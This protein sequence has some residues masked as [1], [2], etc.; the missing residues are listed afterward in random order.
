MSGPDVA[1]QAAR[2]R[3]RLEALERELGRVVVG[4][5]EPLN[6]GWCIDCNRAP[7]NHLRP[8]EAVTKMGYEAPGGDQLALG[9]RIKE[10]KNIN[11]PIHCSGC[12][13]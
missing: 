5:R 6:M 12:H 8:T 4:Q 13:R 2:F 9:T 7:E 1:A 3:E 10:E 11:P